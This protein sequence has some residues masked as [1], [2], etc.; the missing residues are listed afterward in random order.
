MT[1]AQ[2]N[3]YIIDILNILQIPESEK[4]DHIDRFNKLSSE[5]ILQSLDKQT[6]NKIKDKLRNI[7]KP[8]ELLETIDL[9]LKDPKI[10]E[11]I[12]TVFAS[13]THEFIWD[14]VKDSDTDKKTE[15]V[16]YLQTIEDMI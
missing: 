2:N 12:L 11:D 15:V 13:F 1:K 5:R 9:L 4:S 16:N 6:P 7:T 14:L 3:N 10:E 8:E